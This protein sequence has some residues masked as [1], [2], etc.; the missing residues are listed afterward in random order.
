GAR[1]LPDRLA[2]VEETFAE[3]RINLDAP[4]LNPGSEDD[5]MPLRDLSAPTPHAP[6]LQT[7]RDILLLT[8]RQIGEGICTEAI[9]HEGRCN[10]IGAQV[11]APSGAGNHPRLV[12]RTLGPDLYDGTAGVALFLAHLY[13]HTGD[14]QVY[15]T[16]LGAARHALSC[17]A[18]PSPQLGQGAYTGWP[19]TLLA[20]MRVGALLDEPE[21]LEEVA[22]ASRNLQ[23]D[24]GK[25]HDL[26]L[27][28][29]SAGAIVALLALRDMLP[30]GHTLEGVTRLGDDLIVLAE[31]RADGFSWPSRYS[32]GSRNLT[33]FSHGAAGIG[34]AL[35]KLFHATGEVRYRH[36]AEMAFR[37]ERY[38]FDATESNWPDFREVPGR[39]QIR[40]RV[41]AP[42]SLLWCHGAPGIALSR[43]YAYQLLGDDIYREEAVVALS[44][45]EAATRDMLK[46]S[47]A[48]FSLCHGLAGNAEIVD[49][50]QAALD[51]SMAGQGELSLEVAANG[52]EMYARRDCQWP[53]GVKGGVT[54]GLMLGLAGIGLFY[55]RLHDP[56]IPSV[57]M[58]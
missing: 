16:A 35:L 24:Y 27:F 25:G 57:L 47:T 34:Y 20:A 33:G 17:L 7:D 4:Y 3:H 14:A 51:G 37:Y 2:V 53:C 58:L 18:R 32:K 9:W 36:A 49:I 12:Y 29:G 44:T 43:L 55:L 38:W 5:Y 52:V 26:D 10:L 39:G 50:G 41:Q 23:P 42:C 8:A 1:S 22:R 56:A 28:S 30:G 15:R 54:P 40:K 45:T 48:N 6:I 19:G 31:V 11:A 21:L 46:S 13:A